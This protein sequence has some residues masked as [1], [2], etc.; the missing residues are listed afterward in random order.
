MPAAGAALCPP[1][2]LLAAVFLRPARSATFLAALADGVVNHLENRAKRAAP[3][4]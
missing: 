1:C 3:D 4:T 2:G